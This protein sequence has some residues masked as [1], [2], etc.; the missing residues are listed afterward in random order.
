[1]NMDTVKIAHTVARSKG[2]EMYREPGIA[3]N[4][5]SMRDPNRPALAA[6]AIDL[7]E[8][9][10]LSARLEDTAQKLLTLLDE[11]GHA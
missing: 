8:A 6:V 4:V 2:F 10:N 9:D 3:R 11:R 1:M 5:W 7:D